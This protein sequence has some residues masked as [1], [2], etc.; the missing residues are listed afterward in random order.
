M[1]IDGEFDG[2]LIIGRF[3]VYPVAAF[4]L[5]AELVGQAFG[6]RFASDAKATNQ[7]AKVN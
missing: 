7:K 4:S 3:I 1:A 2:M 6:D 5:K